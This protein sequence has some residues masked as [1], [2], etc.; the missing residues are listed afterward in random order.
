[1]SWEWARDALEFVNRNDGALSILLGLGAGLVPVIQ[2]MVDPASRSIFV[3]ARPIIAIR[4]SLWERNVFIAAPMASFAE[5]TD[6]YKNFQASI[7]SVIEAFQKGPALPFRKNVYCA[8]KTKVS[9]KDFDPPALAADEVIREIK[10]AD[11][12]VLIY[13]EPLATSAL[14]EVGIALAFEKPVCIFIKKGAKSPFLLK[15]IEGATLKGLLVR[16]FE[17]DDS[18]EIAALVAR[19]KFSLFRRRSAR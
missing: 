8:L 15:Q 2:F 19:Y 4:R 3:V 16:V 9:E 1:M 12:F 13:P 6:A 17:Y 11:Y 10:R 18:A 14:I 5:G 7:G